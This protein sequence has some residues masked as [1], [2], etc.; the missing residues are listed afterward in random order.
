MLIPPVE[1]HR[2]PMM[3]FHILE[4]KKKKPTTTDPSFTTR[5]PTIIQITRTKNETTTIAATKK[6]GL[7]Q[8]NRWRGKPTR[9]TRMLHLIARRRITTNRIGI[10]RRI[11]ITIIRP[12]NTFDTNTFDEDD[13]S[14]F[15]TKKHSRRR[16][17][18]LNSICNIIIVVNEQL[19]GDSANN[20]TEI[21]RWRRRNEVGTQATRTKTND[22][23][24]LIIIIIH[25]D[26]V[27]GTRKRIPPPSSNTYIIDRAGN[28]DGNNTNINTDHHGNGKNHDETTNLDK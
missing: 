14:C 24:L 2:R 10:I 4:E 18:L 5:E 12:P 3:I 26:E 17:F 25:D 6:K 27:I 19:Q 21:Q 9:M 16:W 28:T 15:L 7:K 23:I 22:L 1:Q 20:P 11:V 8:K 13:I